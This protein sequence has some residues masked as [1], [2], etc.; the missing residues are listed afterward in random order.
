MRLFRARIL[1]HSFFYDLENLCTVPNRL[2]LNVSEMNEW[3]ETRT[4][5]CLFETGYSFH[6]TML[7]YSY[8]SPTKTYILYKIQSFVVSN[9]LM[10]FGLINYQIDQPILYLSTF[11]SWNRSISLWLII[12][13]DRTIITNYHEIWLLKTTEIDFLTFCRLE[14]RTWGV[15]T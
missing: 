10:P 1:S 14:F 11:F 6:C 13:L 12:F 5:I 4:Y 8:L 2:L 3:S 15:C 9:L 7:A